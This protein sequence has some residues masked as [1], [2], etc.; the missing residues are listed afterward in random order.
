MDLFD[1]TEYKA[2]LID[3]LGEKGKR[4][5]LR[6]RLAKHLGCQSSFL[7]QV[8][9]G[10]QDLSLEHAERVSQFLQHGEL[11]RDYFLALVLKARAGTVSLREHWES[12]MNNLRKEKHHLHKRLKDVK[13]LQAEQ[14]AIYYSAWYYAA[15]HVASSIPGL[16]RADKLAEFFG[17]PREMVLKVL[18]FLERNGLVVAKSEG[19][20]IGPT[21]VHLAKD[22]PHVIRHHSNWRLEAM[23]ELERG[24]T[25]GLHYS[26]AVT[27]SR[28][29]AVLLKELLRSQLKENL[30]KIASSKEEEVFCYSLDFFSLKRS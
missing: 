23:R 16:G 4:S 5:G 28:E 20:A 15:I 18:E 25:D 6:Q 26:A 21:H 12:R 8:L 13:T 14:T 7:S 29:D 17:L 30:G 10:A 22:S 24:T 9:N 19:Y 27:I 2:Y 1:S 11:E 3:I